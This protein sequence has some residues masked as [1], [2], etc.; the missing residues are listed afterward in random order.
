MGY[1]KLIETLRKEGAEKVAAIRQ[2]V[3]AQ[4]EDFKRE[5]AEKSAALREEFAHRGEE[6]HA[7][8]QR[9]SLAEALRETRQQRL[10]AEHELAGRLLELARQALP[11]LRAEHP[12]E[13]FATLV[14]EL[15]Q[16]QWE[17]VKINPADRKAAKRFFADAKIKTDKAIAGG[18]EATT[19]DKRFRVVNT[20]EKRL[21]RAWPELLPRILADIRR[22][23]AP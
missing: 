13:L 2:E 20:L 23:K 22:E 9:E 10:A 5:T 12:G 6:E 1:E 17:V 21:E 19:D 7:A 11:D 14:K 18:F 8:I 15:P 3:E 4:G 16:G